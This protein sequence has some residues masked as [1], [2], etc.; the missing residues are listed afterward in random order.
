MKN[1]VGP[2]LT[3]GV[4]EEYLLVD[5]VTRAHQMPATRNSGKRSMGS[6]SRRRRNGIAASG[7]P[8]MASS[9]TERNMG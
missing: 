4:E 1:E 2:Q 6:S 8:K 5:K 7:L 9:P 3:I